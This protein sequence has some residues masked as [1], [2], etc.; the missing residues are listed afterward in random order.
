M[1]QVTSTSSTLGRPPRASEARKLVQSR[2][3]ESVF[4]QIF[5]FV[6]DGM[7]LN[8]SD[9][10][11]IATVT[12][13][14]ELRVKAGMDPVKMPDYLVEAMNG[15]KNPAENPLQEALLAAS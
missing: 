10:V 12:Y 8:R 15:A 13:A 6:T 4:D 2:L 5:S 11:A 7:D 3:P 14:N 9:F 1:A